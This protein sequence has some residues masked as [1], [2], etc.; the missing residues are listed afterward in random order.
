MLQFD[1][2]SVQRD[3][4]AFVHRNSDLQHE[5][6]RYGVLFTEG[7]E[8]FVHKHSKTVDSFS[9]APRECRAQQVQPEEYAHAF[10]RHG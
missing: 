8:A 6:Q 4:D 7:V 9:V 3:M 5:W 1:C 10:E 2:E